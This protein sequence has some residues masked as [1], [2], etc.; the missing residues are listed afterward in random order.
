MG[1]RWAG[2]RRVRGQVRKR[3]GRRLAALG[4]DDIAAYRAHLERHPDE[5]QVLDGLC[6]IP[7]SRFYRDR[8]VFAHLGRAA[9]PALAR[10]AAARGETRLRCWS[11]GCASGEEP[12]G[13]AMAWAFAAAPLSP[14]FDLEIVAT[15]ADPHL[16]ERA[17]AAR[18]GADSLKDLPPG[19]RDR[20]FDAADGTF[21]L[22]P[23]FR[24]SVALDC[25]DIRARA[26][27]GRFDLVLCRNMA[28]TYFAEP[29][30]R[31]VLRQIAGAL[32]AGGALVVGAHERPPADAGVL[33]PWQAKLGIY[34]NAG[35]PGR[36]TSKKDAAAG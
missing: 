17:R 19:W 25:Q 34:R 18:Y 12:Y 2:V 3:L 32:V 22:R 21:V 8:E 27:P 13:L 6:R 5:W 30:Q 23:R 10:A 33:A 15:D 11:A 1:L 35:I 31:A 36:P 28:F 14:K 26:P 7:I 9:L 16:I 4:L 29:V 24:A 20:A